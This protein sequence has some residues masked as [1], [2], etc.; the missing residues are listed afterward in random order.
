MQEQVFREFHELADVGGDAD[1]QR[2]AVALAFVLLILT[3]GG[4]TSV[5]AV[6]GV[7]AGAELFTFPVEHRD[8]RAKVGQQVGPPSLHGHR[9]IARRKQPQ[10]LFVVGVACVEHFV[11]EPHS[12]K[13]S[14]EHRVVLKVKIHVV[15]RGIAYVACMRR[16]PQVD[17][18]VRRLQ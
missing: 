6:F 4:E 16:G 10:L 2:A 9:V 5:P 7:G 13:F 1:V 15:V 17:D 14:P 11:E 12:R 8:L 3:Q 18:L